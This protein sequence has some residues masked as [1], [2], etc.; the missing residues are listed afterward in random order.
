MLNAQGQ[1]GEETK[2]YTAV[3]LDGFY[4]F[5][6]TIKR[7]WNDS[8]FTKQAGWYSILFLKSIHKKFIFKIDKKHITESRMNNKIIKMLFLFGIF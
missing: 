8:E 6:K 1:K 5:I 7:Q 4:H 3:K 2:Y